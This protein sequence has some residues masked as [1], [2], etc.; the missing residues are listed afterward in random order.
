MP[1]TGPT[2]YALEN[3]LSAKRR[4]LHKLRE[5]HAPLIK[6]LEVDIAS[7]ERAI[8]MC[9]SEAQIAAQRSEA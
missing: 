2:V 8:E 6:A 5:E 9:E 4:E 3:L 1:D 7:L